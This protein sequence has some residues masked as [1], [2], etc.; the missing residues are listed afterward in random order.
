MGNHIAAVYYHG[1][2]QETVP[3][4]QFWRDEF[5]VVWNRTGADKDIG[6]LEGLVLSEPALGDYRLPKIDERRIRNA[7]ESTIAGAGDNAS[8]ERSAFR[9]SSAPGLSGGW[10][11]SSPT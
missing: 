5:G 4:S 11:T 3:G 7:T 9:C 6:V 8:L 1:D 10:K 2:M